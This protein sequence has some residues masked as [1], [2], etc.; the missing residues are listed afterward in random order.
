M[1]FPPQRICRAIRKRR[2]GI[3]RNTLNPNPGKSGVILPQLTEDL[4]R[5]LASPNVASKEWVIRQYD[6]EV[7][8]GLVLKPLVGCEND[9]PGD[10]CITTPVL[11]SRKGVVIVANGINPK[12]WGY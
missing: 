11:G 8:G 5:I 4:C 9:G 7:Q 1:D 6:H 3:R 10:A 12:V 2:F